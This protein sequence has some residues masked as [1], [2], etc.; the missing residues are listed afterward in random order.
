MRVEGALF[1]PLPDF[2]IQYLLRI[3]TKNYTGKKYN[4]CTGI[5]HITHIHI[6]FKLR[7][8]EIAKGVTLRT[9]QQTV[10]RWFKFLAVN[11]K[12]LW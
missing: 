3:F 6:K 11:G 8:K 10:L 9:G 12:L 2:L 1:N 7:I 5:L 4:T